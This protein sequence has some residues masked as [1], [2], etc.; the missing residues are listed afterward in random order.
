MLIEY[1][2]GN[3]YE[4]FSV[5]KID[6]KYFC[7]RCGNK[8]QK[9]FFKDQLGVY[10]QRCLI[11]GKSST[12]HKI[13][14]KNRE[15]HFIGE[16]GLK[17]VIN[18]SDIQKIASK[19]C[20]EAFNNGKNLLIYA[21]CGAGK[22]E[23]VYEVILEALNKGKT[24]CFATPRKDVVLELVP[25]FKRDFYQVEIVSLYGESNE[26]GK[27]GNLYVS[28]TH[29]LINFYQYFDL[30]ILDEVDA[31]P[32][33][34]NKMLEGFVYK[35]KKLEAPIIF[36]TATPSKQLKYMMNHKLIDYYIIPARFHKYPIPV[37]YVSLTHNTKK[38]IMM[39]KCPKKIYRW[40]YKRERQTFIFVPSIELGQKLEEILGKLFYCKFVYAEMPNRKTLINQF[41]EKKIQFLITTTILE[42]GVTV[43]NVD[44][45]IINTDDEIFDERAIVQI[46]GRAGRDVRYPVGDVYLFADYYTRSIKGAIKTI[47]QMNK[48]TKKRQLLR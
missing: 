26:K 35:A 33:Y 18:L 22:T 37:P 8:Y 27:V 11:F 42:R 38:K 31:F 10:C 23:I 12:Y 32:Y 17:K 5:E 28:T 21:V 39:G 44:V 4:V 40:L 20:V 47:K 2:K 46:S 45:C 36:L 43:S 16:Y 25:R 34:N 3:D 48:L 6:K 24:V 41:R 29:Q 30:V 14:R 19:K 1:T 9:A 15:C 7:H 13:Y